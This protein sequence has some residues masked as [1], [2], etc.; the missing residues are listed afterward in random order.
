M[1]CKG[2]GVKLQNTVQNALG[3]TK[4]L[5][6]ELC[7]RC[8]KIRNYNKY[9]S[10]VKSND[11]YIKILNSIDNELVVLVIDVLNIN[12]DYS[13][14]I[15]NIKGDVLVVFTKRD[16]LSY[17]IDDNKILNYDLGFDYI[18]SIVVSSNKN[19]NFD[20]LYSKILKYKK[21]ENVYVVGY[22]NVGK[23]TLINKL[24]YNY[25]DLDSEI[26]VSMLP[27]TTLDTIEIK[28]NDMTLI[29]TPGVIDEGNII[30]YVDSKTLKKIMVKREIKPVTYQV[31]EKQYIYIE[32]ICVIES[33]YN[34]FTFYISNALNIK[35][36]KHLNTDLKENILR[37]KPGQDIVIDGLGFIKA[38]KAEVIKIYTLDKVNVF[39]RDNLI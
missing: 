16:G 13:S 5:E 24:I 19:Y 20:L 18:D 37:I 28:L 2:C 8:F 25:S 27:S 33:T 12:E 6:S 29:D 26:T 4:T 36:R 35:R 3:Y 14:I 34:N 31:K 9:Q 21:S 39:N 23:S 30:N 7:E 10:V 1:K 17:K 15:S 11:D 22:S 38:S 32:D